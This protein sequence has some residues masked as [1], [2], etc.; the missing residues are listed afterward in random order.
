[1]HDSFPKQQ[2]SSRS[3]P[4]VP[5]V[6]V[7]TCVAVLLLAGAWDA[8]GADHRSETLQHVPRLRPCS[9]PGSHSREILLREFVGPHGCVPQAAASSQHAPG[10]KQLEL[11]SPLLR[12]LRLRGA[13]VAE[14]VAE[15]DPSSAIEEEGTAAP[16]P[17]VTV[18]E[19]YAERRN[20]EFDAEVRCSS[21][22]ALCPVNGVP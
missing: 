4:G 13:G 11:A 1:M 6:G 12:L 8:S 21:S 22:R 17:G 7:C 16:G 2:A 10:N 5:A 19:G 14:E 3:W 18:E 20:R 9:G 15:M